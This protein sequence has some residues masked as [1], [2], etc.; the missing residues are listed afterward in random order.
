[1]QDPFAS[2]PTQDE[3][4]VQEATQPAGVFDTP[5][6]EAPAPAPEVKEV[7][8]TNVVPAPTEGKIV[9]TLKGG[10]G[11][12]A[13]WVV[14]HASSVEESDALLDQAFADYLKKVQRVA[15][16]FSGGLSAPSGGS[17]P[18]QS[19]RSRAPQGATEPPPWF[20]PPPAEGWVY[21]TGKKK[22]GDGVYHAW[23]PPHKGG[24]AWQF[25][26]PPQ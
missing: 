12:D 5:P 15:S 7:K 17:A 23:A 24:G 10:A 19:P 25:H 20:P 9:T 8:V 4:Q 13:P 6:P 1:M 14:I 2:A 18:Q 3:A 22:N 26:N 21:K 16:F 11:F